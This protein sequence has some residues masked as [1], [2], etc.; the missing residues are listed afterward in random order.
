MKPSDLGL[1]K[2]P[3]YQVAPHIVE[4]EAAFLRLYRGEY[5]RLLLLSIP[6][7]HGKSEY[8]NLFI[9]WLLIFNPHFRILRVM[10]ARQDRRNGSGPRN[11]LHRKIWAGIDRSATISRRKAAVSHF[12]MEQG[13]ELRS[14]GGGEG[15]VESWTFSIGSSSTT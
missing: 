8:A 9:S 1:K 15:D 14:V 13:G 12:Q 10:A 4:M 2:I 11:R 3:G 5:R 6:I 7:R